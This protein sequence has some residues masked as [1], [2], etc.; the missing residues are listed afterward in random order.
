MIGVAV[1]MLVGFLGVVVCLCRMAA[2]AD[3]ESEADYAMV[4]RSVAR[5]TGEAPSGSHGGI[6]LS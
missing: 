5:P 2:N 4:M 6:A 3:R 1:L